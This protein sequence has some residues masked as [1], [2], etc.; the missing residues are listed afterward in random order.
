MNKVIVGMCLATL[1]I[2]SFI[3]VYLSIENL[4]INFSLDYIDFIIFLS[5][6]IAF[7]TIIHEKIMRVYPDTKVMLPFFSFTITIVLIFSY[8]VLR[9]LPDYQ[10]A[11]S[12][13]VTG[14]VIGIGWWIQSIT[15][16]ADARR[17]HT[18]NIIMSSRTSVEYQ[19]RTRDM[20]SVF[21]SHAVAP[22]LAEWRVSPQ[23][24]EFKHAKIPNKIKRALDGSVYILNYYE[25]LSQGIKFRDLDDC[26]LRECFSSI[27]GGL[28]RKNFHLIIEAQKSDIK[29]YEGVIRLTKEWCGESLVEKYRANPTNAPIGPI[30]PSAEIIQKLLNKKKPIVVDST[31]NNVPPTTDPASSYSSG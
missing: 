16:A 29:A 15:T 14:V 3:R 13:L 18:L 9:Y 4:E 8:L 6:S 26:L 7:L 25:F 31:S 17:S 30:Y 27:L 1:L 24:D 22:Q 11:L 10:T 12:I 5:V 21:R 23:K 2:L 19:N 28:E 20:N